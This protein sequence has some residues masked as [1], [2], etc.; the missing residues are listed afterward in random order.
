MRSMEYSESM[1]IHL[2]ER[3][4]GF[5]VV[6]FIFCQSTPHCR[7]DHYRIPV[8]VAAQRASA[9]EIALFPETSQI[10]KGR[11]QTP[12]RRLCAR[13]SEIILSIVPGG[14]RGGPARP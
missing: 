10:R 8:E 11:R 12:L 13:R 5:D 1:F 14:R 4:M 3:T 9:P 7:K 2:H 6:R